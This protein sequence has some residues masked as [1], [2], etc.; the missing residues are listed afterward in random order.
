LLVVVGGDVT[1]GG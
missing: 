1:I